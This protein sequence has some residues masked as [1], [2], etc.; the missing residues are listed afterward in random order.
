MTP[1]PRPF[2]VK[3]GTT[4]LCG[5]TGRPQPARLATITA[6]VAA[7][8]R[9]G[10][11]VVLVT[12]GAIATGGAEVGRPAVVSMAE[13]QALAAIGQPLLMREYSRYFAAR[14]LRVAQVLLTADDLAVRRRYLNARNTMAALLRRRVVPIVN[15]NDTV[16]T[17][18]IRIGDNDTLS[19]QVAILV[20]ADML[21]ILS[22]V[23]GLHTGD[24]R[25]DPS[26]RR[27]PEVHAVS[28]DIERLA[29]RSASALGTG[30][31]ATK[32]AAARLATAAGCTV[33]VVDGRTSRVIERVAAGER[34]GT[35]FIPAPRAVAG[36]KR[37]LMATA[38]VRG[39]IVVDDGAARA[40]RERGRSLLPTGIK[41]VHGAFDAGD[42][43]V[44]VDPGGR[45]IGRGI[46]AHGREAL[47]RMKGRRSSEI[48]DLAAGRIEAIHRD[49]LV[50]S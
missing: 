45:E 4:T 31:M 32:I 3:V 48:G 36:R 37:W 23:D 21:C 49:N 35:W 16:A 38:R 27:I 9:S 34:L 14:G 26:A 8:H 30:G 20:G 40:V 5:Q 22:D 2:V 41:E 7:L 39:R 44:V 29:R 15:E 12:S 42:L 19:A 13:R 47:E 6:Q 50:L 11:P 24:P 17:D 46:T 28:A 43:V 1:P 10:Q 25:R 18:E 33:V